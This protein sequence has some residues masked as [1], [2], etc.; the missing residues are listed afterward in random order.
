VEDAIRFL[1]H[2]LLAMLIAAAV[3]VAGF[4]LL[5]ALRQGPAPAAPPAVLRPV[6]SIADPTRL[7]HM[8]SFVPAS[9]PV[10][11]TAQAA[12]APLP[13][14]VREL[15][16]DLAAH[17]GVAVFDGRTGALLRWLPLAT[18]QRAAGA[19]RIAPELPRG[20]PLRVALADGEDSARRSWFA[21]ADVAPDRAGDVPGG[22]TVVLAG[23]VQRVTVRA[24]CPDGYG[25]DL[26][27][28]RL[29]DADWRPLPN[30]LRAGDGS[31]GATTLVLGPGSYE[32]QPCTG[33]PWQPAV[34]AVP[35]PGEVTATF[36]R[37]ARGDRP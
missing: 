14:E 29:G 33:G 27:L 35:G 36:A 4:A 3:G 25:Q 24:V 16:D 37:P 15:P 9:A 7:R 6:P 17:S 23:P 18:A 19:L 30:A 1:L 34:I 12:T 32:L 22:K 26:Q 31:G 2:L 13:I 8:P 21:R 20:V 5:L 11:H 28:R 10:F